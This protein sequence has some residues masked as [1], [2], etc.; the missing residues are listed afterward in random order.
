MESRK[1]ERTIFLKQRGSSLGWGLF[2]FKI[3]RECLSLNI[4]EL[5]QNVITIDNFQVVIP[6]IV[7]MITLL[8]NAFKE[9]RDRNYQFRPIPTIFSIVRLEPERGIG[10]TN[11]LYND[12][13]MNIDVIDEGHF[14]KIT[15]ISEPPMLSVSVSVTYK[16]GYQPELYNIY[17]IEKEESYIIPISKK[18]LKG[19]SERKLEEVFLKY[20]SLSG[21]KLLARFNHDGKIEVVAK[22][23]G[24]LNEKFIS[25][26]S[27]AKSEF[28]K[29]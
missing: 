1:L 6:L 10:K 12:N 9:R 8:F 26:K 17:L 29:L 18:D 28:K 27:R 19:E 21:Q 7:V 11:I 23:F 2:I 25:I 3:R 4:R 5:F 14:L 24:F 15:N 20:R 16:N 22:R 13:I